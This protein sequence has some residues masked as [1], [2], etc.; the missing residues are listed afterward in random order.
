MEW[1]RLGALGEFLSEAAVERHVREAIHIA[2]ETDIG[3]RDIDSGELDLRMAATE[4]NCDT[5]LAAP[6]VEDASRVMLDD[7]LV[8]KAE[9]RIGSDAL[10]RLPSLP[11]EEDPEIPFQTLQL[12]AALALLVE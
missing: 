8:E 1:G 9:L 6:G 5:A 4:G 12:E 3:T 11:S 10:H 2:G 7:L